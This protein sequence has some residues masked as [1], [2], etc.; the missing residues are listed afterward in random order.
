[1]D[2]P[3][4]RTRDRGRTADYPRLLGGALCLDFVN[5]ID[6]RLSEAP[7]EF[8]NGYESV[9]G[10]AFHVGAIHSPERDGLLKWIAAHRAAGRMIYERAIALREAMY[11]VFRAIA[12]GEPP[13][14]GELLRIIEEYRLGLA[15]A[16]LERE[17]VSWSW[18]WGCEDEPSHPLWSAAA[19]AVELLVR[20]DLSRLKECTGA[21][22]CGWLF[23]D[24]SRNHSRRW[25]SMEGCGSRV[26][27]RRMYARSLVARPAGVSPAHPEP[28][29]SSRLR[30]HQAH[31]RRGA[32]A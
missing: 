21:N 20:G 11:R 10:W 13:S 18:T 25:C 28:A 15:C 5:T 8:I 23:Y 9:V 7:E 17:G 12:H 32:K 30:A 31:A 22:D 27:M 14:R 19:S 6:G 1:M 2:R 26:K 24:A 16:E 4:K 3:N 29:S